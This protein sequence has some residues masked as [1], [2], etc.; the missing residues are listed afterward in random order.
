[1]DG[2]GASS[3]QELEEAGGEVA[4]ANHARALPQKVPTFEITSSPV[5]PVTASHS[6]A[7]CGTPTLDYIICGSAA[8]RPL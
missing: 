8:G 2:V 6:F 4:C 1:M 3:M 7:N 5:S